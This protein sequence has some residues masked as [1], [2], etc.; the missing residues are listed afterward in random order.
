[1][2][3]PADYA[4]NPLRAYT[5]TQEDVAFAKEVAVTGGSFGIPGIGGQDSPLKNGD[6][7]EGNTIP[8]SWTSRWVGKGRVV[9]AREATTAYDGEAS[10]R[11]QTVGGPGKGQ[12][13][14]MVQAKDVSEVTLTAYVKSE[15]RIYSQVAIQA[16]DGKWKSLQYSSITHFRLQKDWKK[17]SGTVKLPPGTVRFGVG[18]LVEGEGKAWMDSVQLDVK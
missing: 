6:M 12:I 4:L 8:S 1:M 11:I 7:E 17:I 15:G 14:Q 13:S 10:L 18:L 16:F 9:A 5:V 2:F 3:W